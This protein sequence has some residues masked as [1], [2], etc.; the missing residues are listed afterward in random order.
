MFRT[1]VILV[2]NIT[3]SFSLSLFG[4]IIVYKLESLNHRAHLLIPPTSGPSQPTCIETNLLSD[5]YIRNVYHRRLI[6][7]S[8]V[9]TRVLRTVLLFKLK[10][11]LYYVITVAC[12]FGFDDARPGAQ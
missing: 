5:D 2:A 1:K 3:Y 6:A 12:L 4:E 7:H 10:V 9:T 8:L 11:F